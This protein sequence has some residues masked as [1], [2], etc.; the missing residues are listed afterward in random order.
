[1]SSSVAEESGPHEAYTILPEQSFTDTIAVGLASGSCVVQVSSSG[2]AGY[3]DLVSARLKSLKNCG[4]S[5]IGLKMG[6][7]RPSRQF[8]G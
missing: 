4:F 6:H 5:E 2:C 7:L 8:I 1:M 3:A